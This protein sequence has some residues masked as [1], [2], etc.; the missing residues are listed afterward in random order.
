ML[1]LLGGIA[2][3][4]AGGSQKRNNAVGIMVF[5]FFV[6]FG[7]GFYIAGGLASGLNVLE[8]SVSGA[9]YYGITLFMLLGLFLD[10]LCAVGFIKNLKM[11]KAKKE[12]G[13]TDVK[14]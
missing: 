6:L 14:S 3:P 2:M 9:G 5:T 13:D 12:G 1:F 11:A 7:I 8:L 10:V 4:L